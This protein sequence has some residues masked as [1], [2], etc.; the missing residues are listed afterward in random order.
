[1]FWPTQSGRAHFESLYVSETCTEMNLTLF[2]AI[3]TALF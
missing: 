3:S 1:M 2:E